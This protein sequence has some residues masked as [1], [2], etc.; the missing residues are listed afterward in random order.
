MRPQSPCNECDT[1][2]TW[3]THHSSVAAR[4]SAAG[5]CAHQAAAGQCQTLRHLLQLL[6]RLH[7]YEGELA[8][9]TK[10]RLVLCSQQHSYVALA[11]PVHA[12]KAKPA[13]VRLSRALLLPLLHLL[14][15]LLTGYGAARTVRINAGTS[16]A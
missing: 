14:L 16:S 10:P 12:S 7:G 8:V 15:V 6:C 2:C 11:L 3:A 13:G 1:R 4:I 9:K 5:G